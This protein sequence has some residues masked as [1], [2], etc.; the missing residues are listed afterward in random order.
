MDVIDH[1][2]YCKQS[3][4]RAHGTKTAACEEKN[5]V[6]RLKLSCCCLYWMSQYRWNKHTSATHE[7]TS[8]F[9]HKDAFFFLQII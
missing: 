8:I 7:P 9:S 5:S 6:V 4:Q 2:L 3:T 1:L